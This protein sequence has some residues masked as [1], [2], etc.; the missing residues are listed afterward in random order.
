MDFY[1]LT[2]SAKINL[3]LDIIGDRPDGYH[4]LAMIL[5]SIDLADQIDL[6]P[7]G[8][9]AIRLR[10][11]HPEVPQNQ[12]NIA[13]KAAALMATE[14]NGAFIKYGGVDITIHKRI[15]IGAGLAGGSTNGAAV[16][17]GLNEMWKLGLSQ[18][19]LLLLAAK[20]GSDVPFC[21]VGG[22]MMALGRG[23]VISELPKLNNFYIVLAKYRHLSIST[24]WAYSAFRQ[25]YHTSY[26]SDLKSLENRR[27]RVYSDSIKSAFSNGDEQKIR[28]ILYNDLER[29]VLP[30]HPK[31][32]IL[33]QEFQKLGCTALMSG[34]GSTV[35][36][37]T[38]S[39]ADAQQV[40]ESI[41]ENIPDPDLELWV[42]QFTNSSIRIAS[43]IAN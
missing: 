31:L 14:F 29:V 42:S 37:L 27:K 43:L 25:Q 2:A 36:A 13:Y 10:C 11:D 15:P 16:L 4:E 3:Y 12:H 30:K 26:L 40:L 20:L 35:F 24:A 28:N 8:T 34:S 18:R 39:K 41:R 23:E 38:K 32:Q 22:T 33:K 5:Q 19:Q 6:R 1:S 7:L 17:V 9:G 21:L